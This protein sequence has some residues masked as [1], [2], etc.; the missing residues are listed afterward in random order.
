MAY[1]EHISFCLAKLKKEQFEVETT[2]EFR[3]LTYKNWHKPEAGLF[4]A[5]SGNRQIKI[6]GKYRNVWEC[7]GTYMNIWERLGTFRERMG[8][9]GN[10]FKFKR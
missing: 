1:G 5:A 4:R 2:V 7:M 9:F 8:T 6:S 10:D 3:Q